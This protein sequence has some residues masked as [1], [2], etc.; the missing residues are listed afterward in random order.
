[1]GIGRGTTSIHDPPLGVFLD[2]PL[3]VRKSNV[4]FLTEVRSWRL[5][6]ELVHYHAS[7]I[8]G[9]RSL[10]LPYLYFESWVEP[11]EAFRKPLSHE[12][13]QTTTLERLS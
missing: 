4:F 13:K 3:G 6:T 8:Q 1:M 2:P 9:V 11:N 10:G 7:D 12:L 5:S